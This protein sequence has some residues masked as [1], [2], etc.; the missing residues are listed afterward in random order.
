[1]AK[2]KKFSVKATTKFAMIPEWLLDISLSAGA[3][4]VYGALAKYANNETKETFVSHSTLAVKLGVSRNTIINRIKELENKGCIHIERRYEDGHQK[5]NNYILKWEPPEYYVSTKIVEVEPKKNEDLPTEVIVEA[6]EDNSFAVDVPIKKKRAVVTQ[7]LY[8]PLV[9]VCGYDPK[10]NK[11]MTKTFHVAMAQLKEYGA[12]PDEIFTKAKAYRIR[13]GSDTEL[14][15]T[16]LA[17]WWHALDTK[18]P[19]AVQYS[20]SSLEKKKQEARLK[21][22]S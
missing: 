15:P 21:E 12:T 17:K 13:F 16:A 14:T 5:S 7:P 18:Q 6:V 3:Y 10:G 2:E 11:A 19:G 20:V 4:M 8:R 22:N 9:D 1:M